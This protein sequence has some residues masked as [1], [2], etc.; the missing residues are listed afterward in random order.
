[1]KYSDKNFPTTFV[2]DR[3]KWRCGGENV[4]A[5]VRGKGDTA[6]HNC[7]GFE[8][9]LGQIQLQIHPK[10]KPKDLLDAGEPCETVFKM[11]RHKKGNF[12][13]PILNCIRDADNPYFCLGNSRFAVKAMAINDDPNLT[14]TQRERALESLA[15]EYGLRIEFVGEY[16]Y[17]NSNKEKE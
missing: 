5:S 1:M 9:C 4:Q 17:P 13:D 8:C 12:C 6:L 2:I 3:S 11:N 14:D 7:E 10:L 15:E 16:I